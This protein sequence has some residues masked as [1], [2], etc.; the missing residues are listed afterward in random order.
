[1]DM[2]DKELVP[3]LIRCVGGC[4][5]YGPPEMTATVYENGPVLVRGAKGLIQP[6]GRLTLVDRDVV[7]V[8]RCGHS[9]L[10]PFCN[11]THRFVRPLVQ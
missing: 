3:E 7:A 5:A 10:A 4:V 1:M 11:G 8:C 9:T 6:D 2:N